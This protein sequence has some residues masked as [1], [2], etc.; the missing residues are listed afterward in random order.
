[1]VAPATPFEFAPLIAVR[2]WCTMFI[3][4]EAYC[5]LT[6]LGNRYYGGN[7]TEKPLKK[8]YDQVQSKNP[9]TKVHTPKRLRLFAGRIVFYNNMLSG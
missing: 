6:G 2:D 5:A 7:K 8:K 1:M 9:S 4:F 3:I